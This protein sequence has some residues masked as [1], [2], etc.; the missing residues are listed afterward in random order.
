MDIKEL[1][2]KY[3]FSAEEIIYINNK[4]RHQAKVDP[5]ASKKNRAKTVIKEYLTTLQSEK[6]NILRQVNGTG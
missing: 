2:Q 6:D 4:I 5:F 1:M 3:E